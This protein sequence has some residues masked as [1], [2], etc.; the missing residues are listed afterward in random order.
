MKVILIFAIAIVVYVAICLWLGWEAKH[1][2]KVDNDDE[3]F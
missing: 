2:H 3:R 1:A